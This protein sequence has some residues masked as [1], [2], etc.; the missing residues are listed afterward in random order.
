MASQ[1][2]YTKDMGDPTWHNLLQ[3]VFWTCAWVSVLYWKWGVNWK[4]QKD[5]YSCWGSS[6]LLPSLKILKLKLK[7]KL[8]GRLTWLRKTFD[9]KKHVCKK[10]QYFFNELF[11]FAKKSLYQLHI[12]CIVHVVI[13]WSELSALRRLFLSESALN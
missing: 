10:Q 5:F 4:W 8:Y 7:D 11:I 2:E 9:A 6:S 13:S 12:T 1:D 3:N